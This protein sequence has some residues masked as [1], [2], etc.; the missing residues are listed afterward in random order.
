MDIGCAA[1]HLVPCALLLL[2]ICGKTTYLA[3][4]WKDRGRIRLVQEE[5]YTAFRGSSRMRH[6]LFVSVTHTIHL[7]SGSDSVFSII[8]VM[9]GNLPKKPCKTCKNR[10]HAVCLYKVQ[11][12]SFACISITQRANPSLVVQFKPFLE[13][14]FMS[15]RYILGHATM[16]AL[17]M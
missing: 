9:D 17:C 14:S 6:L 3:I 16:Y 13:L 10:F 11:F 4:E 2:L 7:C 8:S 12:I 5:R 15:I 1:N